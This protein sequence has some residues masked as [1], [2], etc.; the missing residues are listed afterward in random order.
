MTRVLWVP[1]R[2]SDEGEGEARVLEARSGPLI[3]DCRTR[4]SGWV[5]VGGLGEG[6]VVVKGHRPPARTAG[7]G[8]HS[9]SRTEMITHGLGASCC[10]GNPTTHT[11]YT[12]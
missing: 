9:A 1:R 2:R 4:S 5:D 12:T 8:G 11:A 7:P 3:S 6:A 10:Q